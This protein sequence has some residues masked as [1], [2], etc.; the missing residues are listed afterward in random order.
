VL[1]RHYE[2]RIHDKNAAATI[3]ASANNAEEMNRSG[4]RAIFHR[5][6]IISRNLRH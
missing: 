2:R 6:E 1:I 3:I 4:S 5:K